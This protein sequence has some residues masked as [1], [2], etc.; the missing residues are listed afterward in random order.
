VHI[1]LTRVAR[2]LTARFNGLAPRRFSRAARIGVAVGGAV[3]ALL[4]V[5]P[6]L[7]PAN[8]FRST[9]EQRASSALG[10]LEQPVVTL[11]RNTS[12][13]WNYSSLA[14]VSSGTSSDFAIGKLELSDGRVL[15]ASATQ[16][17]AYDHVNVAASNVSPG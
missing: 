4:V 6:F 5:A 2:D 3:V 7:I 1:R 11:V 8:R 17:R 13:R 15:V 16:T 9:I 10:R 12:G 14:T